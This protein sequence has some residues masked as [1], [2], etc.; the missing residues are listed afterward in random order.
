MREKD[1]RKVGEGHP[2][3]IK[4]HGPVALSN[5]FALSARIRSISSGG[6]PGCGVWRKQ[7]GGTGE[8]RIC[9][10]P[11]AFRVVRPIIIPAI[12]PIPATIAHAHTRTRKC[13]CKH[14]RSTARRQRHGSYLQRFPQVLV[15][16]V[17]VG[18]LLP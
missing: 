7:R 2:A 16:E 13:H 10:T 18:V 3:I 15:G 5:R 9:A 6:Q 1:A 17:K 4:N 14:T 8:E 12:N 11:K